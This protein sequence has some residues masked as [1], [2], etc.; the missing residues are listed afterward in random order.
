[1]S[2]VFSVLCLTVV[3]VLSACSLM[4]KDADHG[5]SQSNEPAKSETASPQ[6]STSTEVS[7][8]GLKVGE[9]TG[10][11]TDKGQ[12]VELKYAYAGRG[13]RFGEP[14]LIV[15]VTD[16]PI[17]PDAVAEEIKSQ[18]LFD[19]EEIRGLEYVVDDQSM[20]VRFHPSQYQESTSNKLKDYAVEGDIVRGTDENNDISDGKYSRTVKFVARIIK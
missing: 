10:S 3:V 19:K 15:L 4:K 5:K 17:P 20:W 9:A 13:E 2:R 18:T 11:Y 12:K 14:S 8:G 6:V 7:I 16:K 1:M